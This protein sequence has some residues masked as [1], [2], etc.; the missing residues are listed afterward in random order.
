MR[1]I[2]VSRPQ[3]LRNAN[4]P[5]WICG[6]L[7]SQFLVLLAIRGQINLL[8]T[9]VIAGVLLLAILFDKPSGILLTLGYLIVMGDIRRIVSFISEPARFDLL[10][11]IAPVI[12]ALLAVP[13]LVNIRLRDS[14]S[15]AV[16]ALFAIMVL[17]VFN[18]LQGGLAVGLAGA[19][20]YIAPLFWFW[21]GRRY[22][23]P[24]LIERLLNTV[25][26]P[27]AC[28]A[29]VL[30]LAQTYI[31]F[32]PWEDAW[33]DIA[34]RTYVA[35]HLGTSIR[36]FGFSVSAAEYATMIAF[37]TAAIC[38]KFL[39]G[40]RIWVIVF[41]VLFAGV[42]L[43]SGRSVIIKLIATVA[44]LWP[45]RKN[46]KITPLLALRLAGFAVSGLVAL[47][48]FASH[49]G[50][51][52]QSSK[53][54][55]AA[56]AALNHLAGGLGHPLDQRYSTAGLHGNMIAY[57]FKAGFTSPIGRGLGSTTLAGAKLGSD[58]NQASSEVDVSDMFIMLGLPGGIAYLCVLFLTFGRAFTYLRTVP[59]TISL[60]VLAILFCTIGS[61]LIGGQYSTSS[62][63]F[64][65]IGGL[66]Y[67]RDPGLGDF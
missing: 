14:L 35:L 66:V 16:L 11:L 52:P 55:S 44:L 7:L 67:Q 61:W 45:L 38:G 65:M 18:P 22:G 62:I 33:I 12:A 10:L 40:K 54:V 30:G 6:L 42:V 32:L 28:L 9:A 39:A 4:I 31:G 58:V 25:I 29:A 47:S 46:P 48:L 59:T 43:A 1:S 51:T 64:F 56:T 21:I 3:Y 60:P 5:L 27:L 26:L 13:I 57:G 19:I 23:S 20:F 53:S 2:S 50:S 63:V 17:E 41:P 15:K 8:F 37:A 24:M 49:F 34:S 36:A